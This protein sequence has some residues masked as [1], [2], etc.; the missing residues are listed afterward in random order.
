MI[1]GKVPF[2]L[3]E[4]VRAHDGACE[5]GSVASA[6]MDVSL[7]KHHP[8]RNG[9]EPADRFQSARQF[10]DTLESMVVIPSAAAMEEVPHQ[11]PP[12]PAAPEWG[13]QK[14]V[15]HWRGHVP[16]DAGDLLLLFQSQQAVSFQ[17]GQTVG[18]YQIAGL[19]GSG[20][21]GEVFKVEHVIT[22][23]VEAMKILLSG[24]QSCSEQAQRFLREIQIQAS[25][26]I[27]TSPL[28]TTPSGRE[29]IW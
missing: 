3:Q 20:G 6:T 14:L 22:R 23:R 16:G 25:L 18:D 29:K 21:V 24:R 7:A 26:S 12:P 2:R 19:I 4:P 10:R 27:P 8:F 13:L 1:T 11:S 5:Y 28:Y 9:Q 15:A 17:V